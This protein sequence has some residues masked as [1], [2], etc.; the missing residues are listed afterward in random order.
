VSGA[1][2]AQCDLSARDHATKCDLCELFQAVIYGR[3]N[4]WTATQVPRFTCKDFNACGACGAN[5]KVRKHSKY[6]VICGLKECVQTLRTT[7]STRRF[8]I[9][10]L[11]LSIR[12]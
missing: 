2:V 1:Q 6:R 5:S 7:L 3:L 4:Q 10:T 8:T 12:S 11:S 9:C